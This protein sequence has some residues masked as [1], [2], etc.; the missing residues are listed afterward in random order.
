M[1]KTSQ[2]S[3]QY[4]GQW[5]HGLLGCCDDVKDCLCAVLCFHCFMCELMEKSGVILS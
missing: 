3:F 2:P 4:S 1:A 5:E